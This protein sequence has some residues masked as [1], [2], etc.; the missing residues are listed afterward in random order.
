MLKL[1]GNMMVFGWVQ[2]LAEALT[3]MDSN[4]IPRADLVTFEDACF[5]APP[6]QVACVAAVAGSLLLA[7]GDEG[8]CGAHA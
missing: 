1:S 7:A 8:C 4:G 2:M 5:P 6:L 3:L